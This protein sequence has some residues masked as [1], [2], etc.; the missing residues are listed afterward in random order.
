MPDE[1]KKRMKLKPEQKPRSP[2][3]AKWGEST[4]AGYQPIPNTLLK[5]QCSLGLGP[6]DMLVLLNVTMHWWGPDSF[7]FPASNNIAHRMGV[8]PRTVQR[9][10]KKM[11][12]LGLLRRMETGEA[13]QGERALDPRGLVEA[14][15]KLAKSDDYYR[16]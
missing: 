8:S 10:L 12:Q 15:E 14:L 2:S 5:H 16:W 13:E 1:P 3:V 7:P 11:Q 9:S 4:R 6:T